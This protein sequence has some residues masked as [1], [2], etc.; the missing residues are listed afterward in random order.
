MSALAGALRPVGGDPR[1]LTSEDL[2]GMNL[3]D[4]VVGPDP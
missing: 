3:I 2:L 1:L 4:G